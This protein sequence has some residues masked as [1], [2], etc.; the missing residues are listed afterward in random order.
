[1][2][3]VDIVEEAKLMNSVV[4]FDKYTISNVYNLIKN[5]E[6]N[7][8]PSG[9][10][11]V[12]V[13]TQFYFDEFFERFHHKIKWIA[14][15]PS[16]HFTGIG[17]VQTKTHYFYSLDEFDDFLIKNYGYL[18]IYSVNKQIDSLNLNHG[19]QWRIRLA[20]VSNKEDIRD[21]KLDD[22]LNKQ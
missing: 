20:L 3:Y 17:N 11:Y 7:Y 6:S 18:L 8:F 15:L 10:I 1:M 21:E 16:C 12:D 5:C 22:I 19:Y 13:P 9:S 2:K 4:S 14:L